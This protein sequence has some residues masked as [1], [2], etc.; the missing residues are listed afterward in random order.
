MLTGTL[1]QSMNDPSHSHSEIRTWSL[2]GMG[3]QHS[4]DHLGQSKISR[5]QKVTIYPDCK[6][7]EQKSAMIPGQK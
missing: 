4:S 2:N 1:S 3:C 7:N 6:G 5:N